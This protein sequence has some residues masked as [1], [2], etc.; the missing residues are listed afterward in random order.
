V[1]SSDAPCSALSVIYSEDG[2][3]QQYRFYRKNPDSGA[4]Q[5]LRMP[6]EPLNRQ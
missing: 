3:F 5:L 4:R 2:V 1:A 6:R